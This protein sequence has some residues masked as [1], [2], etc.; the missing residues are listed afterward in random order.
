LT[1]PDPRDEAS[2]AELAKCLER[3]KREAQRVMAAS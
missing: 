2:L 3:A 1:H